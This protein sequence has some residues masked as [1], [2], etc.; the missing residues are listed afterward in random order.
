MSEKTSTVQIVSVVLIIVAIIVSGASYINTSGLRGEM[1][2]L[3]GKIEGLSYTIEELTSAESELASAV[4]DLGMA[5]GKT[6][7][8][9]EAIEERIKGIEERIKP[10]PEEFEQILVWG[11]TCDPYTLDQMYQV[12]DV[13]GATMSLSKDRLTEPR[14]KEGRV[15]MKNM[16]IES[17]E[18]Y[19]ETAWI[20]HVRQGVKFQTSG[21]EL[22]AYHIEADRKRRFDANRGLWAWAWLKG[23]EVIDKYTILYNCDTPYALP[24]LGILYWIASGIEDIPML[25]ARE[26]NEGIPIPDELV[27]QFPSGT[28]PFKVERFIKGERIEYVK[29]PDYWQGPL[30]IDK[31][32]VK[33]I[34]DAESRVLALETGIC[35]LIDTVP[36]AHAKS[37]EAKGFEIVTRTGTR[38]PFIQMNVHKP[39]F[40]DIR[41]RM[42]AQYAIDRKAICDQIF[43]GYYEPAYSVVPKAH[44]AYKEGPYHYDP[45]KAK[46][47]L[48]EAGYDGEAII[49]WAFEGRILYDREM[50]TTVAEMLKEVGLNIKLD[51]IEFGSDAARGRE[52]IR[53][54]W[55]EGVPGDEIE[56]HLKAYSWGEPLG[57]IN[58]R[59][60][61]VWRSGVSA[62]YALWGNEEFDTRGALGRAPLPEEERDAINNEILDMLW[63]DSVAIILY[64]MSHIWAMDP[65]VK[66]INFIPT[67]Y[68]SLEEAYIEPPS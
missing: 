11:T 57:D 44:P 16:L 50:W 22:T 10:V 61:N 32:V 64:H 63:E 20:A 54:Y 45:E 55:Q 30:E 7:E 19:N 13:H 40:D 4:V 5:V 47:L 25:E 8:E 43:L 58:Y 42:A 41:V 68:F 21:E 60:Y 2:E 66:G 62:N 33:P 14:W 51:I 53:K 37:L 39:P 36:P 24:E 1:G 23:A 29:N 59:V 34:P 38:F 56:Y 15:V 28:G 9:I 49:F 26:L 12:S 35:N 52:V 65:H 27:M 48:Q 31:V 67:D 3:S 18:Q 6:G 17:F 46:A